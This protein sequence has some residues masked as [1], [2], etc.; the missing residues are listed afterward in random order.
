M[1]RYLQNN[2]NPKVYVKATRN[3]KTQN[4]HLTKGMPIIA[5]KTN[6]KLDILNSQTFTITKVTKET[7]TYKDDKKEFTVPINDFHQYFYLGFCITVYASQGE[8]FNQK[9]TIYDWDIACFCEKAKYVAM[10]RSTD[11]NLI[12]IA[13]SN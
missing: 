5:H 7:L 1:E 8:T 13:Q 3:Q 12:Q 2:N 11:I 9:Y 10:S 6:K 4:V